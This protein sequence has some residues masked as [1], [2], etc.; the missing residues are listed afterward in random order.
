MQVQSAAR[1][2]ANHRGV[3]VLAVGFSPAPALAALAER[4]G[5]TGPFLVDEQRVLYRRL[6]FGRAP[7]W[8]VYSRGTMARYA[9]AA[10]RG[11][12]LP[13]TVEDTRQL[14]GDA[15]LQDGVVVMRW[16]PRSPDDRA[17]PATLVDAASM[18][19]HHGGL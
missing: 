13:R 17:D 4:L 15:L 1:D 2:D 8:R 14:G 9:A 6:E 11:V 19:R 5:W 18:R 16:L 12:R 10:R 7:L 3:P